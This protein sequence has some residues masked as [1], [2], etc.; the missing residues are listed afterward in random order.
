MEDLPVEIWCDMLEDVGVT[1]DELRALFEIPGVNG[2]GQYLELL[3]GTGRG[4]FSEFGSV[5]EDCYGDGLGLRMGSGL[6]YGVATGT[7]V[8]FDDL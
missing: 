6:G 4:I 5:F 3:H 2:Y 7:G 1:T 8:L